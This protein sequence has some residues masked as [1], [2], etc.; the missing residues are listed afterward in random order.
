[1]RDRLHWLPFLHRVTFKLG[2]LTYKR[3]HRKAPAYLSQLCPQV[4]DV[5]GRARLRSAAA[6][7]LV[8]PDTLTSTVG[9][10]RLFY[11]A[12]S[13]W[14]SLPSNLTDPS[15][16]LYTFRGLLKSFLFTL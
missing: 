6:G 5:P 2:G 11:A 10:R 4:A 13:D 7:Q 9:R 1:M 3:L 16:S 12:H 14:T 8:V 15:I